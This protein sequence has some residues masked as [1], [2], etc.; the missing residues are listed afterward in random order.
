MKKKDDRYD[1]ILNMGEVSEEEMAH[2][3]WGTLHTIN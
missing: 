3:K 1:D 2:L